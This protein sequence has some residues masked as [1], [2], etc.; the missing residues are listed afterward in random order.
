MTGGSRSNVIS[1]ISPSKT[2][3]VAALHAATVIIPCENLRNT[4]ARGLNAEELAEP[5]LL[6]IPATIAA[7]EYGNN[8]RQALIKQLDINFQYATNFIQEN[9]PNIKV[10]TWTA[11]YLMWLDVRGISCDSDELVEYLRQKTGLIVSPGSIYRGNGKCFIRINLACPIFM[12]KDGLNR[13]KQGIKEYQ[14]N[15]S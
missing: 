1:H 2:F 12:V 13:L 7:Y 9:L 10:I 8:W 4:V 5:N 15:L 6:A 11:T 3:N 14:A